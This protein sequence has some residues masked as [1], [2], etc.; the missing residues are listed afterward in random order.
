MKSIVRLCVCAALASLFAPAALADGLYLRLAAGGGHVDEDSV[1]SG[2]F[3]PGYVGAASIGYNIF[4]PESI[5]D[6]RFELEASYRTN[7][8]DELSGLSS[9]GDIRAYNAMFNGYFDFRNTWVIVPY[10][11][12]GFGASHIRLDH[13]GA[14]GAFPTIDDDDTVFAYQ[15]MAGFTYPIG[16]NMSFGLEYRFMETEEFE[17]TNSLGGDFRDEYN[18]HS[19]LVTL[20]IGF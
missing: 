20:T 4:F 10:V 18:H 16:D 2:D 15:V 1:G 11:G 5:A 12:A 17:F 9:D 6:M 14:G 19:A 3:D 13:D 8:L 7:D